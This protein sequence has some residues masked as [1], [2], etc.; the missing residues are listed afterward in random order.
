MFWYL[1]STDPSDRSFSSGSSGSSGSSARRCSALLYRRAEMSSASIAK[2][3]TLNNAF[4]LH[5][6]SDTGGMT[7]ARPMS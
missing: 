7:K 1:Y 4:M 6:R 3:F 5:L 2:S